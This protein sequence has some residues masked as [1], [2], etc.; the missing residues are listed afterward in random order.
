M[1]S[2][3][4]FCFSIYDLSMSIMLPANTHS[5]SETYADN[6]ILHPQQRKQRH[7]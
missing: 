1:R 7:R 5:N 3:T 4:A 2:S 6:L